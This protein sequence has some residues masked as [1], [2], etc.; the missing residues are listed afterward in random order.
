[1]QSLRQYLS[2]L[3][4]VKRY[5]NGMLDKA[6]SVLNGKIYS[7]ERGETSRMEVLLAQQTYDE[8]RTA[9]IETVF[10]SVAALIELEKS[11]GIWDITIE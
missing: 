5:E 10:N 9:Y 6:N 3:E 7:Y 4:Q 8:L 11:A 2:F 1:M